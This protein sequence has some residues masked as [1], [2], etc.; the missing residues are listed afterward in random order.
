MNV[1]D[2]F[3]DL[4]DGGVAVVGGG[5]VGCLLG[6]Y[7][8]KHGFAVTIFESRPDPRL[9]ADGGRSINL[10]LTSRGIAALMG[11]SDAVAARVMGITVPVFGRTLHAAASEQTYQPYGPDRSYCNFSV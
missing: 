9:N 10:V 4:G 7:L 1:F 6:V 2:S 5:L 11:A 8:R 3:V